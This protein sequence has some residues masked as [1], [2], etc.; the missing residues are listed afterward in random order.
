MQRCNMHTCGYALVCVCM[1]IFAHIRVHADV[2]VH[3]DVYYVD[4][5]VDVGADHHV[6]V[7]AY[8]STCSCKEAASC[9]VSACHG[10]SA[11]TSGQALLQRPGFGTE[12]CE[13]KNG[14]NSA[15]Q[16]CHSVMLIVKQ[17]QACHQQV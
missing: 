3:V 9:R 5:D 17:I 4:V 8:S 14:S 7:C 10:D 6:Y 13:A 11:D 12:E 1:S 2:H 16:G 15:K